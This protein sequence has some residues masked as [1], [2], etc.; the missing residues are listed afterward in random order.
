MVAIAFAAFVALDLFRG[1]EHGGELASIVAA[2]GL[3]YLAAAALE[4]PRFAWPV[5]IGSVVVITAAKLGLVGMD[6]TWILLG[7]A[8][9]F[10]G[11]GL[12]RGAARSADGLPLQTIA[13][14]GFGAV[15]VVAL[16][17]NEVAGAYLVAAGLFAHAAWD[18][19]HHRANKVV[20]R[21]LAEFCCVLDVLLAAAIVVTTV[22]A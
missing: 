3:V 10:L 4:R 7:L 21:S 14:V 9:L 18:V 19:Y 5:F 6:A 15:A 22:G 1:E 20:A 11:Y 12:L 8:A 2:S 16:Y 13:M 17:L